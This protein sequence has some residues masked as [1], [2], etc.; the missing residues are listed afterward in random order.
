MEV[1]FKADKKL[2]DAINALA[3]AVRGMA[4]HCQANTENVQVID[5]ATV[6]ALKAASERRAE[7]CT[8]AEEEEEVLPFE[9]EKQDEP[10]P[11][12]PSRDEVNK[13]AIAKIQAK[14]RDEVKA[15]LEKYGAAKVSAVPDEHLAEF[16]AALEAL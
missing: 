10:K 15:L 1:T 6:K 2:L 9:A 4:E 3:E 16:K 13:L 12:V 8:P 5:T 14:H 11:P 7:L